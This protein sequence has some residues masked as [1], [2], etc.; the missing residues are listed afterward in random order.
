MN[1]GMPGAGQMSGPMWMPDLPPTLSRVLAEHPQ[2]VALFPLLCLLL[3]GL[4]AAGMVRMHRRGDTW[5]VGRSVVWFL[6]VAVL[7]EATATGVEG[8]GMVLMSVHMLQHMVLTMVVPILLLLGAPVT[9][10]LRALPT[11]G[12]GS[13]T[14]RMLLAALHSRAFR[15][16]SSLPSRWFFFLSGL[17]GIYFTPV[18]DLLMGSV[19]GH[20]LMLLHFLLSGLLFFAPLVGTDPMPG[21]SAPPLRM[22]ELLA[23]T[24]FHA[25]FGI[26]MMMATTPLVA[27]YSHP[28][29]AWGFDAM[30]D[31]NR[32]GGIAWVFAEVPTLIV[33]GVIFA[34]WFLSDQRAAARRDRAEARADAEL[35]AYNSYLTQLAR[36]DESR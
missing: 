7:W 18:F 24:P 6:G 22:I 35:A 2:P 5:P 1:G 34:Q 17:Y 12:R 16:L 3:A 33:M 36:H 10:A 30:T 4:Y 31:Q 8:Y 14:R 15:A 25:F 9:L 27:F 13:G 21:R 32:A 29:G 23:S 19:W 26:A 28:P 11:H 20:Y